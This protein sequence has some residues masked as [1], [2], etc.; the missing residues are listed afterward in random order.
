MGGGGGLIGTIAGGALTLAGFPVAG[1]VVGMAG[2]ADSGLSAIKAQK[3]QAAAQQS[4]AKQ[5][6]AMQQMAQQREVRNAIREARI[7]RGIMTQAGA[8]VG[9]TETSSFIGGAASLQSQL[10]S[11]ISFLDQQG[12]MA[13]KASSFLQK[14][15][16]IEAQQGVWTSA[17]QLSDTIFGKLQK[18]QEEQKPMKIPPQPK[19]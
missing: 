6:K 7:K 4:A 2:R 9:A 8:N 11:N 18:L 10:S 5:Q 13:N 14:A 19:G 3:K 17:G 15:S 16:S 1:A 12:S